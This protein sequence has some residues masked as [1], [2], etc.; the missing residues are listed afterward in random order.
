PEY[1]R[2][3]FRGLV[4]YASL[5]GRD[6]FLAADQLHFGAAAPDA[7]PCRL[8][9]PH[10]TDL[11]VHLAAPRILERAIADP[12]HVL[13]PDHACP[14]RGPRADHDAARSGLKPHDIE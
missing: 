10:G 5:P 11:H 13:Q 8:R 12:V 4:E 6:A 14:K 2:L 9:R 7:E 3:A 1:T